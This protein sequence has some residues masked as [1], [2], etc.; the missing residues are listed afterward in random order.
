MGSSTIM[1]ILLGPPACRQTESPDRGNEN[2]ESEKRS[3]LLSSRG[4]DLTPRG[5]LVLKEGNSYKK[6]HKPA[7]P[8]AQISSDSLFQCRLPRFLES[9]WMREWGQGSI[10]CSDPWTTANTRPAAGDVKGDS[11]PKH[12]SHLRKLMGRQAL[13]GR[14]FFSFSKEF[15]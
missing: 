13:L 12:S 1:V 6:P 4:G 9:R 3:V 14:F 8:S 5:S 10:T 11:S 7:G 15:Q 2:R